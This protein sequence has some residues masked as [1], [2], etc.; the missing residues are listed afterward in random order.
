MKYSF[1]ALFAYLV[2]ALLLMASPVLASIVVDEQGNILGK[3]RGL[4]FHTVGQRHGFDYD[5][6]QYA[7]LNPKLHKDELPA[8]YV[9]DKNVKANKLVI[10]LK[11][12]TQANSLTVNHLHLIGI[13]QTE[14]LGR[15]DLRVRIRHTGQ[16]IGCSVKKRDKHYQMKL[17]QPVE[18]VA[19]GQSAAL[20]TSETPSRCVGG[21]TLL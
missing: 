15:S 19:S 5:K 17:N 2:V 11:Q 21:A 10:G 7:Q 6:K 14:L 18:G 9:I 20:Y 4:W 1:V 13:T 3:H 12:A 16:L 8:L